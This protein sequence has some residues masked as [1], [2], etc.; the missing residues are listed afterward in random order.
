MI[1]HGILV[2]HHADDVGPAVDGDAVDQL[3]AGIAVL[4]LVP[5]AVVVPALKVVANG[6]LVGGVVIRN[7]Q[8]S[9]I[10]VGP[11]TGVAQRNTLIGFLS[12]AVAVDDQV[13]LLL[14]SVSHTVTILVIAPQGIDIDI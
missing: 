1:V 4:V 5:A 13:D 6:K 11:G 9:Q 8:L 12:V 3:K 2:P 7:I 14:E 10:V